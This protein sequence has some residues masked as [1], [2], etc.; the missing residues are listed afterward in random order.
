MLIIEGVLAIV[1]TY[2]DQVGFVAEGEL[3]GA[4]ALGEAEGAGLVV[5]LQVVV[6]CLALVALDQQQDDPGTWPAN[7]NR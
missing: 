4:V 5:A 3:E 1:L 7:I 6:H 2:L